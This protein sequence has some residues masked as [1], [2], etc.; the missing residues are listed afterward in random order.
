MERDVQNGRTSV[1]HGEG[2]GH[3]FTSITDANNAH[4]VG[5][6]KKL[7]FEVLAHPLYNLDLTP[8]DSPVWSTYALRGRRFTTDQQ[9]DVMVHAWLVSQPKTFYCEVVKQLCNDGQSAL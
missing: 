8:L 6:L 9:L 3:Q 1:K 7:N 5:N 2:I 4:T